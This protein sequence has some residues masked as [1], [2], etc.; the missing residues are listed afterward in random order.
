MHGLYELLPQLE[1]GQALPLLLDGAVVADA[2]RGSLTKGLYGVSTN[3]SHVS[4][5]YVVCRAR[6]CYAKPGDTVSGGAWKRQDTTHHRGIS[7]LM[8]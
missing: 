7:Q 6:Q 8:S 4:N 5:K 1:D 3:M 2:K